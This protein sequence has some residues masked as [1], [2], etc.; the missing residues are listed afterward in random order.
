[1]KRLI[2]TATRSFRCTNNL[3]EAIDKLA[4]N[5]NRHGSDLIRDAVTAYVRNFKDK[6][7]ELNED[8]R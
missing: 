5:A 1:M 6:P 7:D 3:S 4:A 2:Y 8:L